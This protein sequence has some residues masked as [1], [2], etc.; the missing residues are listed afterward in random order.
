[1]GI[2]EAVLLWHA[3]SSVFAEMKVFNILGQSRM[4]GL[5]A[6]SPCRLEMWKSRKPQACFSSRHLECG[7]VYSFYL[8]VCLSVYQSQYLHYKRDSTDRSNQALLIYRSKRQ[9]GQQEMRRFFWRS[10]LASVNQIIHEHFHCHCKDYSKVS[11]K[12]F[13]RPGLFCFFLVR[14]QGRKTK[15]KKS[16]TFSFTWSSNLLWLSHWFLWA[17]WT[18]AMFSRSEEDLS[19][20]INQMCYLNA[21]TFFSVQLLS[22]S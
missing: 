1:M 3:H 4:E 15:P 9:L 10:I 12:F 18:K 5:P 17:L 21:D 20:L 19:V 14:I 16:W 2:W 11:C 22:F 8:S 7:T 6:P 13:S